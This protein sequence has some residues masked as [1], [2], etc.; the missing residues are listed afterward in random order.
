MCEVCSLCFAVCVCMCVCACVCVRLSVCVCVCVCH[1]QDCGLWRYAANLTAHALSCVERGAALLRWARHVANR[2]GS[3]WRA[4]GILV[5]AGCCREALQV[6]VC[7]CQCVCLCMSVCSCSIATRHQHTQMPLQGESIVRGDVV[8]V[9]VCVCVCVLTDAPAIRASRLCSRLP[10]C[11]PHS[12]SHTDTHTPVSR[13]SLTG[14]HTQWVLRHVDGTDR[15]S[16]SSR[17]DWRCGWWARA[18]QRHVEK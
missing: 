4:V 15:G 14:T 11:L 6:H 8:C 13:L 5:S 9:C 2:E 18:C 16:L 7:V 12:R 3:V 10:R 1:T 17:R